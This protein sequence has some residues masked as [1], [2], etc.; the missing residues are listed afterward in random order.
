MQN[1]KLFRQLRTL[2]RRAHLDCLLE[3]QPAAGGGGGLALGEN[4][5]LSS[6][7]VCPSTD[8][9]VAGNHPEWPFSLPSC[10]YLQVGHTPQWGGPA[11]TSSLGAPA[12]S[13][14]SAPPSLLTHTPMQPPPS[15]TPT[16]TRPQ[17]AW[18]PQWSGD[19]GGPFRPPSCTFQLGQLLG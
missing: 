3:D 15:F 1:R 12:S 13:F 7:R 2:E 6:G 5:K 18:E 10:L 4:G 9:V 11:S 14:S 16:P 8:G 17:L 19:H